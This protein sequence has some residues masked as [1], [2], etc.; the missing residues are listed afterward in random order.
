[1]LCLLVRCFGSIGNEFY[2]SFSG[3]CHFRRPARES[4][5][6]NMQ[7]YQLARLNATSIETR[8]CKRR[9]L[10]DRGDRCKAMYIS[11]PKRCKPM[12]M[13]MTESSSR[14]RRSD[15]DDDDAA[16]KSVGCLI[17]CNPVAL[18]APVVRS[19]ALLTGSSTFQSCDQHSIGARNMSSQLIVM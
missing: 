12:A 7:E 13:F 4:S 19:E 16:A 14:P 18:E 10:R 9:L 15:W 11:S 2:E 17:R 8:V 6:Q 5:L 3:R 1:M